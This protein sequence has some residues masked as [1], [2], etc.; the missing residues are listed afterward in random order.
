MNINTVTS[1]E[2]LT[3]L[4]QNKVRQ[5]DIE[6]SLPQLHEDTIK[7]S[8]AGELTQEEIAKKLGTS[9]AGVYRILRGKD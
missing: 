7:L 8:L 5:S 1:Q 4:G 6:T 9:K 2:L 3:D